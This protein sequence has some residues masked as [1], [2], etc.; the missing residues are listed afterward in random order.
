MEIVCDDKD[1]NYDRNHGDDSCG[2]GN[3]SSGSRS[4]V[5]HGL[6]FTLIYNFSFKAHEQEFHTFFLPLVSLAG[7]NFL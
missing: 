2:I 5:S 1:H 7:Y 4:S 6:T 3:F